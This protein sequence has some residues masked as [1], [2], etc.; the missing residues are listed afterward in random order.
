MVAPF[1]SVTPRT[2][3]VDRRRLSGTPTTVG[4]FSFAI[5]VTDSS[6]TQQTADQTLALTIDNPSVPAV[7]LTGVSA[8][9]NPTQ[10]QTVSLV[11]SAPYPAALSGSLTI[12]F[13]PNAVGAADDPM[14][15]FS[16]GSRTV[17][18]NIPANGTVAVFPSPVMLLTGT[19]G[20]RSA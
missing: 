14:V 2:H 12:S 20:V 5:R 19:V 18:F 7:S 16:N 9:L 4:S 1:G 6:S 17:S 10:Q 8:D 13:T 11:L 15:M 3:V